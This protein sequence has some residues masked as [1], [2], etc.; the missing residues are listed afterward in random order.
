[1]EKV[2][3]IQLYSMKTSS[4]LSKLFN[5]R[6]FYMFGIFVVFIGIALE[7]IMRM[8]SVHLDRTATEMFFTIIPFS[9]L[10]LLISAFLIVMKRRWADYPAIALLFLGLILHRP[11][12]SFE[13]ERGFLSRISDLPFNY[14]FYLACAFL[15][16]FLVI[17]IKKNKYKIRLK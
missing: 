4:F 3:N 17:Q 14:F 12:F 1:M 9:I 7:N 6:L 5:S 15:I 11:V 13:K 16:V 10:F 8:T 2:E